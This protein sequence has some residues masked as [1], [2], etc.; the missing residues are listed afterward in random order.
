MTTAVVLLDQ[1]EEVGG[2]LYFVPGS[3]RLGSLEHV[4]DPTLGA[5]NVYSV[6]RDLLAKSLEDT[7]PMPVL[8]PPGTV[9]LF[10]CNVIH[11]SGHNMSQRDRRQMYVVY[12]PVANKPRDVPNPR[13]DHTRSTNFAPLKM[14][15]DD[16]ILRAA[17]ARRREP[18]PA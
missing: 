1:A 3:H 16:A 6:R 12:N 8:G 14:V 4:D 13:P 7:R 5:L 2:A 17:A 9:A 11:G 10:H 18:A 15:G